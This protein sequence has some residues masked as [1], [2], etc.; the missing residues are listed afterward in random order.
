MKRKKTCLRILVRTVACMADP[1]Q[2][3]SPISHKSGISL[4]QLDMVLLQNREKY[5]KRLK[6]KTK[7]FRVELTH[8]GLAISVA[9]SLHLSLGVSTHP[10]PSSPLRHAPRF[11]LGLA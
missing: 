1:Q 4:E 9:S 10:I 2:W 3:W 5:E 11:V 6:R 7:R 8:V